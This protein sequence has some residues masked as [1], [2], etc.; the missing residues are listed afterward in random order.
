MTLSTELAEWSK[1]RVQ[2]LIAE[3]T[4]A[5]VDRAMACGERSLYDLAALLSPHARARLEEIARE[6]QRLTRHHFGRTVSLYVPIYLS[7]VCGSDC[8]YCGFS[9][10]SGERGKR[11]TLGLDKL[12]DECIALARR[13]FQ[14]VLLLTGDAPKVAPVEYIAEAISISREFF[15]SVSVEVYAMD[16]DDYRLLSDRGLEGMTLYM[17]TFDRDT[18]S[19]VHLSGPKRDY[20]YRLDSH[21]RAGRAGVRKLTLGV[22]LGL[23]DWRVDTFWLAIQAR[24]LQRHCWQSAV[25]ISFPRLRHVPSR[26]RIPSVLSDA[27]LVQQMLALR[28]FLPEAGFNLSTR[29]PAEFRDHLIPLGITSMSAGSSTRPGGY[30][31][32]G[33]HTLE[34]FEIEDYRSPGE[35]V[36]A[37]R[38]AGYDPVWKDFDLAFDEVS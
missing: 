35:V 11:V 21:E 31:T 18:Y 16:E 7:N 9:P 33:T 20:D 27:D 13:G 10:K 6:A 29:E 3:A 23:F 4:P 32:Y 2:D 30:A 37:I 24:Y 26:F 17:E 12:R 8:V 38:R 5:D 14:S 36:D 22:L 1:E 19:Q 25:S 34:Q 28:L 15:P